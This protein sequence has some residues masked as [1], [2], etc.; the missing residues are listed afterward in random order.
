[1]TVKVRDD[2]HSATTTGDAAIQGDSLVL[3]F[4][5]TNRAPDAATKAFAYYIS[6]A[7][8]GGGS[9]KYTIYRP[10]ERSGGLQAGQLFKDSS[11]YDMAITQGEG[12]CTYALRIPWSELGMRPSVGV[13]FAFSLQVNDNDGKGLGAHMNWGGGLAPNWKPTDFGVVTIVE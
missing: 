11:V 8:P 12:T 13:R 3:G 9:G 7:S 4:D 1:V 2:V 5:P 10:K 6:S